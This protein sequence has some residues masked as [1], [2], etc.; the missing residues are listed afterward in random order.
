MALKNM[1]ILVEDGGDY[2][3]VG[4]A[5][6]TKEGRD[7]YITLN[8]TFEGRYNVS[9]HGDGN[10]WAGPISESDQTGRSHTLCCPTSDVTQ[11]MLCNVPLPSDLTVRGTLYDGPQITD[12]SAF[13][14]SNTALQSP[15]VAFGAQLVENSQLSECLEALEQRPGVISASTY[16]ETGVG[17]TVVL[18]ISHSTG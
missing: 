8:H 15:N 13:T 17:K 3:R 5:D 16:R 12:G 11:E 9:R 18:W 4:K 2:Y 10:V 7:I 14:F 6:T 1:R